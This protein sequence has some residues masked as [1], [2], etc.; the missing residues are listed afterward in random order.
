MISPKILV[1]GKFYADDIIVTT[2]PV[3]NR[4]VDDVL[5]SKV[6]VAWKEV[7]KK[8]KAEGK[9][10]WDGVS[11]RLNDVREEHSHLKLEVSPIKFSVRYPLNK[12][13]EDLER[14]G[15]DYYPRGMAIG[16]FIKTLD[17]EFIFGQRSG[18]SMTSNKIDFIGGVI[19]EHDGAS[20]QSLLSRNQIEIKE[21][22]GIDRRFI[23]EM[24][25]VGVVLSNT[26]NVILITY[27][28]LSM[29]SLEVRNVFSKATDDEMSDLIFVEEK[30]LAEYLE[31]LGG[32]KTMVIE[33]LDS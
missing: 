28:E 27:T 6:K 8:A 32:Y 18:K 22:V 10:V 5:E 3:S 2:N 11:F 23:D 15:E 13:K 4:K 26:T 7:Y 19:E 1:K 31:S 9:Q 12:M 16:G 14:L 24:F 17:G 30:N 29:G 25:V 21:E 20:G 33:L